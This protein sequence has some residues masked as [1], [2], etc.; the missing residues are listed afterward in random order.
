MG[1]IRG[2]RSWM[3]ILYGVQA[4]GNGHISRS[5]E[6]VRSL[7]DLGH[8]VRVILSGRDPALLWDMEV[9]EPFEAFRG[10]T[11]ITVA[12]RVK[13]AATARQLNLIRFYQDISSYDAANI[14]LVITDFEPISARIAKKNK[15]PSIGIGHQYAF[16]YKIPVAGANPLARW[17]IKNY[18]FVDH[19]VGLHW[20][21]FNQPILPPIIPHHLN[22]A[23]ETINNKILVYLPFETLQNVQSL[24][25]NIQTHHFYAY[26]NVDH[27]QDN[28]CLHLRP[29]SRSGFLNDLIECNGVICNAGFELTS[30]ALHLGKRVLVK[31]IAGQMEQASNALAVSK[32]NIGMTMNSLIPEQIAVWLDSTP[33]PPMNYPNVAGILAQWIEKGRW[34]DIEGLARGVWSLIKT[35]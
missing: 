21:H 7:K 4:T 9:F 24:L 15:I 8:E 6:V 33:R 34:E 29:F 25:E 28:G 32:L 16:Y 23:H 11:F 12:G 19:P 10:L 13:Y 35:N 5:R 31:P 2:G 17:I 20:H 22:A 3:K 18:A 27:P 14:D 26:C 30:E 1:F